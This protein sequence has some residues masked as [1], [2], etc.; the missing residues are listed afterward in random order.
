VRSRLRKTA[1]LSVGESDCPQC[2]RRDVQDLLQNGG[3]DLNSQ[4]GRGDGSS[5]GGNY[6]WTM[7]SS[8]KIESG[9]LRKREF[10]TGSLR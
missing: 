10:V 4:R 2:S 3:G 1:G 6:G 9:G 8:T 7:L 5:G